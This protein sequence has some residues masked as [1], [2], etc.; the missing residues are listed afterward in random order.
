MKII[1]IPECE[2][3]SSNLIEDD[4]K[5][6]EPRRDELNADAERDDELVGG[7]R[8]EEVP[9][10]GGL[11]GEGRERIQIKLPEEIHITKFSVH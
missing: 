6:S 10:V 7:D 3:S 4:E 11:A 2:S 8:E 1:P 9:N 5:R